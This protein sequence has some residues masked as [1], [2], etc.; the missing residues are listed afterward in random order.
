MAVMAAATA[1]IALW[2][3]WSV[4]LYRV[5]DMRMHGCSDGERRWFRAAGALGAIAGLYPVIVLSV[6]A[7]GNLGAGLGEAV[8]GPACVLIGLAVGLLTV[9]N[10]G[11][12]VTTGVGLLLGAFGV[13]VLRWVRA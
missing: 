8:G 12:F 6:V 13:E 7:G 5:L 9:F 4:R 10:I 2:F 1:A 11:M 3:W